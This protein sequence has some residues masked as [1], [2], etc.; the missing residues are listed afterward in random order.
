MKLAYKKQS[1]NMD[2]ILIISPKPESAD[3]PF[4]RYNSCNF[5]MYSQHTSSSSSFKSCGKGSFV[6]D[7]VTLLFL[8]FK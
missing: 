8:D 6:T 3:E 4:Y 5:Y 1:P 7:I 2:S